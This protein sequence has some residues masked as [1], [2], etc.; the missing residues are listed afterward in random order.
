MKK[1]TTIILSLSLLSFNYPTHCMQSKSMEE[2]GIF[3]AGALT[4]F[5][6]LKL[7]N[8]AIGKHGTKKQG[9][10][11]AVLTACGITM[12]VGGP[13]KVRSVQKRNKKWYQGLKP[14]FKKTWN[15]LDGKARKEATLAALNKQIKIE[16]NKWAT[17]GL[18]C[19]HWI[20][21]NDPTNLLVKNIPWPV[22]LKANLD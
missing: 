11:G 7:M 14:K 13:G 3:G 15:E 4:T 5:F 21:K 1:I 20:I 12:M 6:G 22:L 10:F 9:L 16:P 19:V 17:K 18:Q 8:H 2:Y